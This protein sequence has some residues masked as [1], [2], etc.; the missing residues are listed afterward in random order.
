ML[1]NPGLWILQR[2][3]CRR[4]VSATVKSST[5]HT[6]CATLSEGMPMHY[7]SANLPV[8]RYPCLEEVP[9]PV[10]GSAFGHL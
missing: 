10:H 4:R 2:S 6:C 7:A 8:L 1:G 5:S 3:S 9:L